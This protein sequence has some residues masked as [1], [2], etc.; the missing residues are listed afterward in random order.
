MSRWSITRKIWLSS[1]VFILGFVLLTVVVQVQDRTT[2]ESLRRASGALVPAARE[3]QMAEAAFQRAI[4]GFSNAII[5]Q[6][7][8]A[9]D[10]P[11]RDGASAVEILHHIGSFRGLPPER[12]REIGG[13]ARAVADLLRESESAYRSA[14]SDPANVSP[15]L[16]GKLGEVSSRIEAAEKQMQAAG[17][18]LSQELSDELRLIQSHTARQRLIALLVCLLTMFTAGSIMHVTIRRSISLPIRRAVTGLQQVTRESTQASGRMAES[19]RSVAQNAQEQA[20][21]IE[22]TSASIREIATST[23]DNA[24]RAGEADRLMR[25]ANATIAH[26][27]Q[28]MDALAQSMKAISQS[29]KQVYDV[30][31]SINEIAFQTNILALNAA[32]EAARA[33]QAGSGFSV[34]AD[35]V[36][37]LA[38]RAA[39]AANNSGSIIEKTMA[40]IHAGEDILCAAQ[41]SFREV[42]SRIAGGTSAVAEIAA[43]TTQQARTIGG[44]SEA[45]DRIGAVTHSNASTARNSAEAASA[46]DTQ[47]QITREH[48]EGLSAMLGVRNC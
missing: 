5:L 27:T 35:E 2:E 30:L 1:S 32:V 26:A 22:Q 47:I 9:L 16:Q 3:A 48:L 28:G 45:L 43:G 31:K 7:A 36:R 8:A 33:G 46:V 40:D 19:G 37:S 20:A 17:Q 14:L 15:E 13:L 23:A 44:I 38:R 10:R 24:N 34:V 6:D 41:A 11:A 18:S 39:E 29:S 12:L 21:S 25:A 4:K 42:S